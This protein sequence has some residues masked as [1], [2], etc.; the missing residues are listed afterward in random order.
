M[1]HS[2]TL[3]PFLLII[4]I[5]CSSGD[6]TNKVQPQNDIPPTDTSKTIT[7]TSKPD[8]EFEETWMTFANAILASD[9]NTLKRI[10]ANCIRCSDCV[11][12]TPKED[13][14]Y[15]EFTKKNPDTWYDKFYSE[16]SFIPIDKFI[17]EDLNLIFDPTLKSRMLDTSKI[18]FHNDEI[19][20]KLYD[21]KCIIS[22]I[23]LK[24]SKL[25]V[26]I[27][28]VI[29]PSSET[30]GFQKAFAFI[31]TKQGYKFCGYSTIP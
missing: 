6:K 19:N 8:K 4:F 1:T 5:S 25:Q 21:A 30:E 23:D 9:L 17:K 12:N 2:K 28:L 16:L 29:D 26:A 13:S 24:A 10:S 14:M 18:G 27:V 15:N 11:T 20:K 3:I 22:P 7:P 31:Q